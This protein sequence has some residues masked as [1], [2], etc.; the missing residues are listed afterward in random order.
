LNSTVFFYLFSYFFSVPL[1]VHSSYLSFS[2]TEIHLSQRQFQL[3]RNSLVPAPRVPTPVIPNSF[4][5]NSLLPVFIIFNSC[6]C[7]G[8]LSV[9][10]AG[11]PYGGSCQLCL[12]AAPAGGSCQLCLPSAPARSSCQL[13]LPAAPVGSSSLSN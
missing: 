7:R 10:P 2:Y 6:A 12:P 13:C 1:R 9:I 4:I 5:P 3:S 8:L 11:G